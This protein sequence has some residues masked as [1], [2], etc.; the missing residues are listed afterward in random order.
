MLGAVFQSRLG[1]LTYPFEMIS[2]VV[3][4]I[5]EL[6]ED[7]LANRHNHLVKNSHTK[8]VSKILFVLNMIAAM[9]APYASIINHKSVET[10]FEEQS[11][12][13]L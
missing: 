13:L 6:T 5:P 3:Q 12:I 9:S 10:M 4:L 11:S 7:R 2:L 8:E 1:N